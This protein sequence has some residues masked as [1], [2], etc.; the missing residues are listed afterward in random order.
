VAVLTCD[1][2]GG[3]SPIA[4]LLVFLS[5][6][7]LGIGGEVES[8][9]CSNDANFIM[10]SLNGLSLSMSGLGLSE[11]EADD[12]SPSRLSIIPPLQLLDST[13]MDWTILLEASD[14][15][16]L[17]TTTTSSSSFLFSGTSAGFTSTIS[18]SSAT[19]VRGGGESQMDEE[20]EAE[21]A[22]EW[23]PELTPEELGVLLSGIPAESV[24]SWRLSG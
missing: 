12:D 22:S 4:L 20:D 13:Y 23:P 1:G 19:L 14:L 24:E 11:M 3:V 10:A 9:F 17:L 18:F 7:F 5:V 2:W 15:S 16:F 8:R 21:S 6:D